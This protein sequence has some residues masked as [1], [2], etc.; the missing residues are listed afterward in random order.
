M[1]STRI[2][3]ALKCAT[4]ILVVLTLSLSTGCASIAMGDKVSPSKKYL[5]ESTQIAQF[6]SSEDIYKHLYLGVNGR[7]LAFTTDT[8]YSEGNPFISD[9]KKPIFKTATLNKDVLGSYSG[10]A[11]FEGDIQKKD[12][13]ETYYGEISIGITQTKATTTSSALAF[14][15]SANP[16]ILL[17]RQDRANA[18]RNA[19]IR[20]LA[21]AA[22]IGIDA[23]ILSSS[24]SAGQ[25]I[26]ADLWAGYAILCFGEGHNGFC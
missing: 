15:L 4:L 25:K 16:E 2:S 14:P 22:G 5:H 10:R 1:P 17:N 6:V 3:H 20:S 7:T 19:L 18:T 26:L 21:I 24:W 13:S 9:M 11:V 23:A 12:S 8:S